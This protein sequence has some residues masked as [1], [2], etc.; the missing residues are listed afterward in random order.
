MPKTKTDYSLTI[1]YKITC[2]D[3]SIKDLYV[4]ST[5]NF[6]KRKCSHKSATNGTKIE[7]TFYSFIRENGGWDNWDMILIEKYQCTCSFERLSRERYWIEKL[8]ASLNMVKRTALTIDDLNNLKRVKHVSMQEVVTCECGS[9]YK[10]MN[11][12]DHIQSDKH[13]RFTESDRLVKII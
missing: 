6:T 4:G 2:R 11:K 5:T 12:N 7:T 10:M 3:L 13:R 8:S 1:M 9:K